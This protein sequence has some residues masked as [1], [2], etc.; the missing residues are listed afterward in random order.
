MSE[1]VSQDLP[2]EILEEEV[3][4]PIRGVDLTSGEF[5]VASKLLTATSEKPMLQE[6]L[7][8]SALRE[9]ELSLS[10]RG[11]R[12]IVRSLRRTHAFPICSRKGKPA[13]YWWGR[14]EEELAEFAN[15]FMAQIED[16]AQTVAIMLRKN[17]PRLAGQ[18]RLNLG[19]EE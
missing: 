7:I 1:S 15:V 2:F 9:Q 4:A 6:E 13:G 14:S 16:E 18:L 12:T 5:F 17:Y 10:R 19:L 8:V 3:L 11:I